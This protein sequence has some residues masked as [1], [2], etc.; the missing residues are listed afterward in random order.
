MADLT[1][2]IKSLSFKTLSF[3]RLMH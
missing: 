1:D 2:M 3:G